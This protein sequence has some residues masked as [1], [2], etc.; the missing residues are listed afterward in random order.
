MSTL[1]RWGV[2][3]QF[4]VRYV[5]PVGTETYQVLYLIL[6]SNQYISGAVISSNAKKCQQ[7]FL[8]PLPGKAKEN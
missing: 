3:T 8:A 1:L 4:I 5:Q 6:Y 7:A 2:T